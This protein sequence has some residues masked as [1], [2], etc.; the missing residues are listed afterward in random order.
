MG[1]SLMS[2]VEWVELE[3][4]FSGYPLV[5]AI[6]YLIASNRPA[7]NFV[8]S[9]LLPKLPIAY[10]LVGTLYLGLQLKNGYPDFHL[11]D[12]LG[13]EFRYLKIWGLLSIFFWIPLLNK[14]VIISLL[15]SIVFFFLLLKSQFSIPSDDGDMV[16]NNIKIFSISILLNI[17]AFLFVG[18]ISILIVRY[19]TQKK[20]F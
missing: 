20:S 17:V 5:F 8:K 2:Y 3:T 4:F 6:I 13:I 12:F 1:N 10:A 14:K 9:K 19:K 18:L 7:T 16:R 11:N 15:H